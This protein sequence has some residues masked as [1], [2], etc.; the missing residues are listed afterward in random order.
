MLMSTL[1]KALMALICL[2]VVRVAI[3]QIKLPDVV[4]N[5]AYFCV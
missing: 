1:A 3:A 4:L 2:V 5:I